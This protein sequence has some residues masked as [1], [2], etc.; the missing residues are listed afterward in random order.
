[1]TS[2]TKTMI[3]TFLWY[4]TRYL[5]LARLSYPNAY[6]KIST[7]PCWRELTLTLW[8]RAWLF[9]EATRGLN[10]LGIKDDA[11]EQRLTPELIEEI[12]RL[13]IVQGCGE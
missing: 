7:D 9:I 12:D 8:G 11:I 4:V 6:E 10:H 13:R 3:L 1:M 2:R 5:R